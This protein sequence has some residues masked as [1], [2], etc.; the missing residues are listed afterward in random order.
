MTD[1]LIQ[2]ELAVQF[3]ELNIS[4]KE[5]Y[6]KM[7]NQRECIRHFFFFFVLISV[8]LKLKFFCLTWFLLFYLVCLFFSGRRDARQKWGGTA[9]QGEIGRNVEW[10]KEKVLLHCFWAHRTSPKKSAITWTHHFHY[11]LSGVAWMNFVPGL[12]FLEK[13]YVRC[14]GCPPEVWHSSMHRHA[15]LH[16]L[17][18]AS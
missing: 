13:L 8:Q 16:T 4:T 10:G 18:A 14:A 11:F 12:V 7:K 17:K 3:E 5:K 2:Q 6:N 1:F 15:C 9:F